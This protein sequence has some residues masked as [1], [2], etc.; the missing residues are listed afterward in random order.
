MIICPECAGPIGGL[1]SL[2]CQSCGWASSVTFENIPVLLTRQDLNDSVMQSYQ[3]NYESIAEEDLQRGI[4]DETFVR[5]LASNLTQHVGD[6]I[7]L[8]VCDVGVGKGYAAKSLL[9][10]G[11][12]SVVA[13]DI[14]REYL[15][16]LCGIPSLTPVIAN[17]ENLP[18]SDEFDVVVSSDVME[19]VLNLGSFL[20]CV[21]RA[22]RMGGRFVVRVPYRESL[23]PYSPHM[24]CPYSFVHLRTFNKQSLRDCLEQAGFRMNRTYYD[25]FIPG[26]PRDFWMRSPFRAGLYN[27]I[28]RQLKR[29][30]GSD[31]NVTRISP[32]LAGVFMPPL[33]IIADVQ[34]VKDLPGSVAHK[35]SAHSV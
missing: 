33:T 14:A 4:V 12:R 1:Y 6:V 15:V 9:E 29:R 30:F 16:R 31:F 7:G 28:H 18:F 24:G 5:D 10:K 17:A 34:K 20:F 13:V 35:M 25:A 23:L 27:F 3:K 22:L 2:S 11:A 21:N 32:K 26:R 19:H 8:D